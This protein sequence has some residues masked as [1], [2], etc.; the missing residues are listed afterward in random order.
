MKGNPPSTELQVIQLVF[1]FASKEKQP[2]VQLYTISCVLGKW[3]DWMVR[4]L[5]E[6]N[7]KVDYAETGERGMWKLFL[8]MGQNLWRYL[9]MFYR[10]MT[11]A[12]EGFNN[13]ANRVTRS[14]AQSTSFPSH[15]CFSN[16]LT[17]KTVMVGGDAW[18]QQYGLPFIKAELTIATAESQ[19]GR[20]R[21]QYWAP[22]MTP[23]PR[24]M[25]WL[26][27]LQVEYLGL[28]PSRER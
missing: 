27:D 7:W 12:E 17:N 15:S 13:Q 19:S 10:S 9:S 3:F 11:S 16:G 14:G 26:P 1:H 22:V 28:L 21:K 2:D 8:R 25:S 23:C 24:G 18:S 4:D 20:S 5:K 6:N